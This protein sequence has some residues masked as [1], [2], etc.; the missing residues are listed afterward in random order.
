MATH[1]GDGWEFEQS[2]QKM[3]RPAS[4]GFSGREV[5]YVTKGRGLELIARG[6]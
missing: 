2:P 1:E 4:L 6:I 3:H 5:G